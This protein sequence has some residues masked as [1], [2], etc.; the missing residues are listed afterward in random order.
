MTDL[1]TIDMTTTAAVDDDDAA[2]YDVP[3]SRHYYENAADV[4]TKSKQQVPT[5]K[6]AS[7]KQLQERLTQQQETPTSIQRNPDDDATK[8]SAPPPT[9]RTDA[10][11]P[12]RKRQ[13]L[14]KHRTKDHAATVTSYAAMRRSASDNVM[15]EETQR[16][17]RDELRIVSELQDELDELV[18]T[19]KRL[20][21]QHQKLLLNMPN[22]GDAKPSKRATLPANMKPP[23][24]GGSSR[25]KCVIM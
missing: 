21:L 2:F 7:D 13:S 18:A 22:Y 16:R 15:Y 20:W 23:H 12:L 17:V 11:V 10:P 25:K 8:T 14:V 1:D 6:L 9:S 19:T 5:A 3:A 24:F 4:M